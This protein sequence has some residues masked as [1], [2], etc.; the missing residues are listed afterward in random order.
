MKKNNAQAETESEWVGWGAQGSFSDL[1]ND[2]ECEQALEGR[3]FQLGGTANAN[4][5]PDLRFRGNTLASR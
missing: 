4:M 2:S 5:C 1:N 3:A